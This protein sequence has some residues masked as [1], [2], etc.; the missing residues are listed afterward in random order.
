MAGL[1]VVGGT[2]DTGSPKKSPATPA[3]PASRSAS[4]AASAQEAPRHPDLA[5]NADVKT[6]LQAAQEYA[7]RKEYSTAEDIYKQVLRN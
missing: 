2:L 4:A 1:A 6:K 7:D 3:T 5:A